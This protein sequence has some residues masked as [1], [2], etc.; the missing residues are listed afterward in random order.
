METGN[1]ILKLLQGSDFR[2]AGCW[3]SLQKKYFYAMIPADTIF[4][5]HNGAQMQKATIKQQLSPAVCQVWIVC[6]CI[7]HLDR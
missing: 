1:G 6:V 5:P 4:V 7:V 2:L 3:K